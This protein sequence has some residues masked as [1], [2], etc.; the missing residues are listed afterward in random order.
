MSD[1]LIQTLKA[2]LNRSCG[3]ESRFLAAISGGLDS[4]VLM[5]L[6]AHIRE[7]MSLEIVIAHYDHQWRPESERDAIF[8]ME[9]AARY[10][11]SCLLGRPEHLPE[12]A[13]KN[14]ATARE[15]RYEFLLQTALMQGCPV[16]LTAHT[17][18]DQVETVLHNILRGTGLAGLSGMKP[19]RS[20]D[21]EV[22]LVRPLLDVTRAELESFATEKKVPYREDSTNQSLDYT[23]NLIRHEVLEWL[24]SKGFES[25]RESILR[26]SRQADDIQKSLVWVV[27]EVL[28]RAVVSLSEEEVV[29]A[30]EVL[31]SLPRHLLRELFVELWRREGWPRQQM[32]FS[33]W[34]R[35]ADLVQKPDRFHLPGRIDCRHKRGKILLTREPG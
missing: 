10:G 12:E 1:Q 26:L 13:E 14:E 35:L 21:S 27:G 8:V 23:R 30:S 16:V 7:E 15:Q 17:A 2:A 9:E 33:E 20:L 28:E 3:S 22:S 24:E 25:N 6:L 5:A 4:A 11:F 32:G 34:D 29:L 31:E 19:V 18:D